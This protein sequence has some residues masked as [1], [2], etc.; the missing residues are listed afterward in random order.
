MKRTIFPA[1]FGILLIALGLM[2]IV[3]WVFHIPVLTSIVPG[4]INMVFNTAFSFF[5]CGVVLVG[6]TQNT[7][8]FQKKNSSY[9]WLNYIAHCLLKFIANGHWACNCR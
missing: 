6:L 9:L 7:P 4:Y 8:L 1:F 2:V 3:G 5:L